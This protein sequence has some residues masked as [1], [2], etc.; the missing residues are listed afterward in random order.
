MQHAH[1][2]LAIIIGL[3]VLLAVG[4]GQARPAAGQPRALAPLPP[5]AHLAPPP[6]VGHIDALGRGLPMAPDLSALPPM[7][8]AD[9]PLAPRVYIPVLCSY[10]GNFAYY[11][12]YFTAYARSYGYYSYYLNIG[13]PNYTNGYYAWVYLDAA[14]TFA[15]YAYY[16][17][18]YGQY[19]VAALYEYYAYVYAYYGQYYATLAYQGSGDGYSYGAAYYA[20]VADWYLYYGYYYIANYCM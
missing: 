13:T 10:G 2:R 9:A 5:I 7:G 20:N 15:Y 12:Q 19:S 18:Y 17:W 8:G 1:R 16:Y 4:P 14:N 11:G 3:T 6:P